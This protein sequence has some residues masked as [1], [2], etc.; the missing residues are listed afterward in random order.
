[1]LVSISAA[2]R[3]GADGEVEA[4]ASAEV[5]R[6]HREKVIY[7]FPRGCELVLARGV[8]PDAELWTFWG[9]TPSSASVGLTNRSHTKS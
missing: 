3:V 4:R 2:D 8:N 9:I 1:M 6:L 5:V 7:V